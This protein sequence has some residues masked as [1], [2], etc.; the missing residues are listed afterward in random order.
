MKVTEQRM[1]IRWEESPI[2]MEKWENRRCR[3]TL[4][5]TVSTLLI[6]GSTVMGFCCRPETIQGP[7]YKWWFKHCL[8]L[9]QLVGL[10]QATGISV[11][12]VGIF[13]E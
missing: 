4:E 2:I 1:G 11:N 10:P 3:L 12:I 5:V 13:R 6:R 8:S 9:S 7:T